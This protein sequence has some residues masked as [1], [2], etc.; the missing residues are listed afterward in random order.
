MTKLFICAAFAIASAFSAEAQ[1]VRDNAIGIRLSAGDGIGA[2]VSYQ[3]RVFSKNR[4][5]F[6]LGLRDQDHYDQVKFMAGFH[7]IIPIEQGFNFYAGPAI[8]AGR[9]ETNHWNDVPGDYRDDGG[10]G[11]IAGVAGLEY[12]FPNI[13]LQLSFDI[14]P[15]AHFGDR[16]DDFDRDYHAL[17]PD[18][19]LAARFTF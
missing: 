2:D 17:V 19:G 15:E 13:P 11:V 10:F 1:T 16:R 8:G 12:V 6:D 9:W 18:V 7:W 4:L 3:R 14:R 5:E